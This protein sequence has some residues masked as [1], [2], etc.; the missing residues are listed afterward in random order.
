[1]KTAKQYIQKY[2]VL[3]LALTIVLLSL[4]PVVYFSIKS[5][6]V[7]LLCYIA[8]CAVG[9]FAKRIITRKVLLSVL[10]DDL[11]APLFRQI[12]RRGKFAGV[13]LLSE[14]YCGNFGN[15]VEICRK[16]LAD[17]KAAKKGRYMYLGRLAAV[18]YL[19]GDDENL[20]A[21]CQEVEEY[22]K[23]EKPSV[24][25]KQAAYINLF[26]FYNAYLNGDWETCEK[27]DAR[28]VKTNLDRI[29]AAHSHA[30]LALAKGEIERA[31]ELFEEARQAPNLCYATYANEGLR[32]IEEGTPYGE[33]L[34][35]LAVTE[36]FY[37]MYPTKVSGFFRRASIV[38]FVIAII[39][40]WVSAAI[41]F[42]EIRK[43]E[44]AK[45]AQTQQG[46]EPDLKKLNQLKQNRE[47]YANHKE[48]IRL[49]VEEEYDNVEVLSSFNIKKDDDALDTLCVFK[50][51]ED[52]VLATIYIHTGDENTYYYQVQ[53]TLP[54]SALE[55]PYMVRDFRFDCVTSDMTAAVRFCS[56]PV[57][58]P[59]GALGYMSLDVNG[60]TVYFVLLSAQ[61]KV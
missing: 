3:S 54:L 13:Q 56:N 18:Y 36:D 37:V 49:L 41:E 59:A 27:L 12:V 39:L 51:D 14:Y 4:I 45:E 30:R 1:M 2:R 26:N 28:Q 47:E 58:F 38:C 43:A 31:K 16:K 33:G 42:E 22:L 25:R 32:A 15:V 21:V 52:L 23:T 53:A 17:P 10:V 57:S 40:L 44:Q 50:T 61:E 29:A 60:K 55:D 19:A 6:T 20:R 8:I 7:A 46:K 9:F 24:K 11:N 34:E 35:P 5:Y 48:K